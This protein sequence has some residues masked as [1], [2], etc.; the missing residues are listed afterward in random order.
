MS[1]DSVM[2][3]HIHNDTGYAQISNIL[4]NDK[5]TMEAIGLVC[6]LLGKP[7]DWQVVQP[8]LRAHFGVDRHKLERI[9]RELITAGYA[10]RRQLQDQ[11]TKRWDGSEYDIYGLPQPQKPRRTN[12]VAS[13][14]RGFPAVGK[15][16]AQDT[17]TNRLLRVADRRRKR[18]SEPAED[19]SLEGS[20]LA[21]FD[22]F[23]T[24]PGPKDTLQ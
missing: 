21:D 13:R 20:S 17:Q 23:E 14:V 7:P 22:D 12:K 3:F 6:Y 16:S 9:M 10:R 1:G 24:Y 11:V 19:R 4:L 8:Q 18:R 15:P 2:I 5:L